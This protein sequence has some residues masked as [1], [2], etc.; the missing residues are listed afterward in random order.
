MGPI[1]KEPAAPPAAP[2][3]PVPASPAPAQPEP[4]TAL[5]TPGPALARVLA[6]SA[7]ALVLTELVTLGLLLATLVGPCGWARPTLPG[8][9]RLALFA[10]AVGLGGGAALAAAEAVRDRLRGARGLALGLV[11]GGALAALVPLLGDLALELV[12]TGTPTAALSGVLGR[13]TAEPRLLPPLGLFAA[14]AV[15]LHLPALA[16]QRSS[17]ATTAWAMLCGALTA[18]V[19]GALLCREYSWLTPDALPLVGYLALLVPRCLL[20]P[21]GLRLGDRLVDRLRRAAFGLS[22]GDELAAGPAASAPA[23][24]PLGG[25]RAAQ[26][27]AARGAEQ[28]DAGRPAEAAVELE[29]AQ[30]QW[31]TA[32]VGAALA[33]ARVQ[34][35]DLL[36]AAAALSGAAALARVG[37]PLT[38]EPR[39]EVWAQAHGH[40][41]FDAALAEAVLA[42][43]AAREAATPRAAAL[44]LLTA[45]VGCLASSVTVLL[46]LAAATYPREVADVTLDRGVAWYHDD[47]ARWACVG[48]RLRNGAADSAYRVGL[49]AALLSIG[50]GHPDGTE[51]EAAALACYERA[52]ALDDARGAREAARLLDQL[53]GRRKD[54]AALW[55]RGAERGDPE[56]MHEWARTLRL[57]LGIPSDSVAARRWAERAGVAGEVGAWSDLARW[58]AAEGD[59]AAVR[60]WLDK[61][62]AA[63][64][65]VTALRASLAPE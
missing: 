25:R 54:A 52:A 3:S 24:R 56:A 22:P 35:G 43:A 26:R 41:V 1:A 7:L 13:L 16:T 15:A 58:A 61:A 9:G 14:V 63:G 39:D 34:T 4:A 64:D 57:G 42:C 23:A 65:D 27:H 47:G 45:L 44:G 33:Q 18:G 38:I 10:L 17:L 8:L 36:A 40:A 30:A 62:E 50:L 12:S 19:A 46:A 55:R 53:V 5:E 29:A 21:L 51:V 37:M 6:R 20:V 31:P 59:V 11:V 49:P 28:L 48:D 32:Q 60:S 2:A